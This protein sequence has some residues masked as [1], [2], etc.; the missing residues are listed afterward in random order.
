MPISQIVNNSIANGT[1]S[2]AGTNLAVSSSS[3][4]NYKI[5][6]QIAA[7]ANTLTTVYTV[8][9]NTS[10]YVTCITACNQ[11]QN[12]M[13]ID[14]SVTPTG[15]TTGANNYILKTTTLLPADTLILE[16]GITLPTGAILAANVTGGFASFSA[17]NVS[18]HAYGV[19]IL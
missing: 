3:I 18:F 19:E 7:V 2:L 4:A 11:S 5:L 1:F 12:T 13:S 8:P 14:V 10:T 17:A 16:P 15:V 6:G 9:A